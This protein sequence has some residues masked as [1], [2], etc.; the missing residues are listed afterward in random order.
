MVGLDRTQANPFRRGGA[1]GAGEV[2]P[3]AG[4]GGKVIGEREG[5]AACSTRVRW[6]RKMDGAAEGRGGQVALRGTRATDM[7]LSPWTWC[8]DH[9][10]EW[11]AAMEPLCRA[12]VETVCV[13][14]REID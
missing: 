13:V 9:R 14:Q 4:R 2:V 10:D 3:P 12:F 11:T 1:A 7:E 5:F 8:M 6:A